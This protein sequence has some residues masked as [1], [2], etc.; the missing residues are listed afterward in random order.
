MLQLWIWSTTAFML[1][2]IAC[3]V[4]TWASNLLEGVG[5]AFLLPLFGLA[6]IC[7]IGRLDA[8]SA[9]GPFG[10]AIGAAGIVMTGIVVV[11]VSVSVVLAVLCTLLIASAVKFAT[12]IAQRK[13]TCEVHTLVIAALP[14][15]LG[16]VIGGAIL[17][18]YRYC[19][20]QVFAA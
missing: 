13:G 7:S 17:L 10:A 16:T 9:V 11:P 2:V 12:M 3:V 18:Y 6:A 1:Q 19:Q 8:D 20:R 4:V 5:A 15:G 14:F